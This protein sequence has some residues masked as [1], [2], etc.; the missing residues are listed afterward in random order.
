MIVS[1][2][3]PFLHI[4]WGENEPGMTLQREDK[5]DQWSDYLVNEQ[6]VTAPVDVNSLPSGEYQLR[7]W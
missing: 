1:G 5:R 4:D 6:P 3:S 2:T 7:P